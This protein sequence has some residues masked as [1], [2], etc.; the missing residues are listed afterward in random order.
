MDEVVK[1][2]SIIFEK[3]WQS[4]E[5]LTDWK[6]RNRTP[7]LKR[8]KRKTWGTHRLVS[9]ALVLSKITELIL[10]ETML[11]RMEIRELVGESFFFIVSKEFFDYPKKGIFN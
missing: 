10:L 3:L 11:R 7:I 6:W 9:F 5:V 4:F 8:G 2:L 1:L